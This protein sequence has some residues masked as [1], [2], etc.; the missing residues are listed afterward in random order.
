MYVFH[1]LWREE[2][3]HA[4]LKKGSGWMGKELCLT[5]VRQKVGWLSGFFYFLFF[6]MAQGPRKDMQRQTG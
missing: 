5:A 4:N 3:F 6:L 1:H 2:S